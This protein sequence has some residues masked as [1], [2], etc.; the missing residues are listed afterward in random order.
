MILNSKNKQKIRKLNNFFATIATDKRIQ[1][2]QIL[3]NLSN[4]HIKLQSDTYSHFRENEISKIVY[5]GN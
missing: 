5:K 1:K 2:W 4:A 3:Y